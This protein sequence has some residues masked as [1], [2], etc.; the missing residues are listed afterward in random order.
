MA[1]TIDLTGFKAALLASANAVESGDLA[2]A[3]TQ[4]TIAQTV[5]A[6]LPEKTSDAGSSIE[7]R[8]DQ[9]EKVQAAIDKLDSVSLAGVS[10]SR[11]SDFTRGRAL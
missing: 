11:R 1:I 5:S 10:G 3:R 7:Y 4:L 9:L 8:T 6:G 2:T